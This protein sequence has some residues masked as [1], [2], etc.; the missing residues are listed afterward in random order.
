MSFA[1]AIQ[2][3]R[4]HSNDDT[5]GLVVRWD[6]DDNRMWTFYSSPRAAAIPP[7]LSP[8]EMSTFNRQVWDSGD[9]K[10]KPGG[11]SAAEGFHAEEIMLLSWENLLKSQRVGNADYYPSTV[12]LVLSKSPCNGDSGSAPIEIMYSGG[13]FEFKKNGCATKLAEFIQTQLVKKWIIRY[14][15]LGGSKSYS[16]DKDR[17]DAGA[18]YVPKLEKV[19]SDAAAMKANWQQ[20]VPQKMSKAPAEV[21]KGAV[22]RAAD[23]L[24]DKFEKKPDNVELYNKMRLVSVYQAQHGISILERITNVDISRVL[25]TAVAGTL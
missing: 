2:E 6:Q 3:M 10:Y 12:E 14:Y 7:G 24:L 22:N 18:Q 9:K 21:Q 25:T 1:T 17:L 23:A 5:V 8:V 16:T 15:D 11:Q 19:L 20:N 13:T 4:N